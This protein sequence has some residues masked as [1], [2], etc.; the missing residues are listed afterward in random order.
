MANGLARGE[1]LERRCRE[2]MSLVGLP[3]GSAGRLPVVIFGRPA[4]ADR[5]RPGVGRRTSSHRG[6][7]ANSALD[8]SVQAA[9]LALFTELRDELGIGIVLISHN[10]AA[11]R[12]VCDRVA[13]M[14]LGRVVEIGRRDDI[15]DDPR[16]PTQKRCWRRPPASG[17]GARAR[18]A[19]QRR[20]PE[21]GG[22]AERLPVPPPLPKGRADMHRRLARTVTCPGRERPGGRMS[23]P[24]GAELSDAS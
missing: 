21:P 12:Q 15:F 22:Q 13:V 3:I 6:R 17:R 9:V 23:L 2:L 4:P 18:R 10:L 19:P 1:G 24:R 11:V 8:V 5:H 14:Y 20:A 7:R 16:H